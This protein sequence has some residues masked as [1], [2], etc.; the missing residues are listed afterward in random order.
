MGTYA[1][2][3]AFIP[4]RKA[5]LVELCIQD[6]KLQGEDVQKFRELC[7][8]LSAY[9]HF[10]S[11]KHLESMKNNFAHLNPDADTRAMFPPNAGDRQEREMKLVEEFEAC[12]K[13]ANYSKLT[14]E[15]W[16]KAKTQE[17]LIT[18]KM[19]VDFNDFERWVCYHRGSGQN[20]VQIKKLFS[21]KE[22]TMDIYER[23][24]LLIK[25]KDEAYFKA[26]KKK[27][28]NLNFTPGKM[29][30]YFYK[31]IPQADLEVLFPNVDVSMNLKDRL[32]LAIPAVG[33]GLATIW[34]VLPA[35][36]ITFALILGVF[37]LDKLAAIFG[38]PPADP[39]QLKLIIGAI[40]GL[41]I[42]VA[43]AFKQYV[44]YKNKRLKFLKDI[45]DTLFF[46]NLDCNAGVFHRVMDEAE[47]EEC[48]EIILAYYHLATNPQGMTKEG[49]DDFIE[50]WLEQKFNTKIDFAVEK[51]LEQLESL[52]GKIVEDGQKEE[53]LPV[54]TVVEKD[55]KG[56]YKALSLD[57]SKTI[58]D[59]IWD[60]Y[61]DYNKG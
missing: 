28:E 47:E 14:D 51:A 22:L 56:V 17:S 12:L 26:K 53:N 15:E 6:G 40:T 21:K 32:M 19:D 49:L 58:V 1:D 39:G 30:I 57:E 43:F 20:T 27:I 37:K 52:R 11:L 46:R 18:L 16:E 7:E 44:A 54:R 34:K 42:L 48:K 59:Y 50:N 10:D 3:E 55:S 60:N 33:A 35:L 2:R 36:L 25:F 31:K 8:I 4:Y 23:V 29:Y 9:Y 61:F 5:D 13:K 45:T 38:I 24:V 41:G